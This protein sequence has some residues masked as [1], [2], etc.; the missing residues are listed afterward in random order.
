[1]KKT[2]VIVGGAGGDVGKAFVRWLCKK[3]SVIGVTR[4]SKP[5]I[6]DKNLSWVNCDL[7]NPAEVANFVSGINLG[8]FAKVVLIHVAGKDKFENT[9]FPIIDP[10]PTIDEEIYG[11]NVNTY[12]YLAGELIRRVDAERKRNPKLKLVLS[13]VAGVAEKYGM[14]FLTSFVEC[15]NIIRQ[16]IRD[17]ASLYPWVSGFVMSTSSMKTKSAL[18]VR[19]YADTTYWLTPEEV[20]EKCL[21]A[22]LRK[23]R[24]YSEMEIIK[25]NPRFEDDYYRNNQKMF[26]KWSREV[27]GPM[28]P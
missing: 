13:T 21:P 15:K 23:K 26:E 3:C 20:A 18:L 10:L 12:K 11:S 1:M 7:T 9:R 14:I 5:E 17:A 6:A 27:Y 8:D 22:L 2:L 4:D 16:Y 28:K 19:P 25:P 24:G